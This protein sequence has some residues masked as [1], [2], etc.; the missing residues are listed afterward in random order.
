[1]GWGAGEARGVGVV[2]NPRGRECM[3]EVNLVGVVYFPFVH[4]N[5]WKAGQNDSSSAR[6][7]AVQ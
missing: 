2:T 3:E 4:P 1:M 5:Y 6:S 7:A